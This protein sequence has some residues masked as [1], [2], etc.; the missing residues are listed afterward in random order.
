MPSPEA[1]PPPVK[2]PAIPVLSK[3]D[4]TWFAQVREYQ[5]DLISTF[6]LAHARAP[7]DL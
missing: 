7:A 4:R 3:L 5:I 1:A 6:A 2:E